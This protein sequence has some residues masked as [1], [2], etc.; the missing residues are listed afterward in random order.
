MTISADLMAAILASNPAGYWPFDDIS[1]LG[2]DASSWE[3]HGT[4]AGAFASVEYR[5]NDKAFNAIT[6]AA[7]GIVTIPDSERYAGSIVTLEMMLVLTEDANTV[8]AERGTG[9]NRWTL[10]SVGSGMGETPPSVQFFAGQH[11]NAKAARIRIFEICH[12]IVTSNA[13]YT[14][15]WVNGIK[16]TR[17]SV[18]SG[19]A[20][21]AAGSA[22]VTIFS[23]LGG[24]VTTSA[25]ISNVAIYNRQLT[26]SE[27]E[28]RQSVLGIQMRNITSP[29]SPV[30][31]NDRS[32]SDLA[33]GDEFTAMAPQSSKR[34]RW[35]TGAATTPPQRDDY[36]YIEGTVKNSGVS[37][38]DQRVA[39][40]DNSHNL[41]DEVKSGPD[42]A[43]RFDNL[44]RLNGDS[45][46][47][48]ARDSNGLL[49]P[50]TADN[51]IP[52]AYS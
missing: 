45:Y 51:R 10:Q 24:V 13:G 36:G 38:P 21:Q 16:S 50:A 41:I 34:L 28:L 22:P 52:E 30:W 37:V 48:M 42:G 18:I 35:L 20:N 32:A 3:N 49:S 27:I 47:V 26:A 11:V 46:V 9:N 6:A 14:S 1:N 12:L 23:R 8:I 31:G 5:I 39:C 17:P 40:F 33:T 19:S 44:P 29:N 7:G 2:R 15:V 4:Q 43:Y 25:A